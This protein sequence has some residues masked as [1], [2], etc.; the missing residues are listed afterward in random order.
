MNVA[1]AIE[2]PV[3]VTVVGELIHASATVKAATA[4]VNTLICCVYVVVHPPGL[5]TVSVTSNVPPVLN[6]CVGSCKDEV[7]VPSPKSH[8]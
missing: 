6:V 5:V 7:G 2:T 8:V 1:E 3:K 4:Q